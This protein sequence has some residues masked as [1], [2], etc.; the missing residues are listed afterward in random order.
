MAQK[1]VKFLKKLLNKPK[2][3]RKKVKLLMKIYKL[4]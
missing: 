1:L 4:A 2:K 3:P